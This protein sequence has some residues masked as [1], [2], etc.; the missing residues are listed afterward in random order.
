[1]LPDFDFRPSREI[2]TVSSNL[3]E[4]RRCRRGG[5]VWTSG[6]RRFGRIRVSLPSP[7]GRLSPRARI[8][9]CHRGRSRTGK[10]QVDSC[11]TGP[12]DLR[13]HLWGS[14]VGSV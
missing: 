9:T 7:L 2:T 11:E 14:G 12:R 3:N 5:G 10:S 1:M 13:P 8:P 4:T 6:L